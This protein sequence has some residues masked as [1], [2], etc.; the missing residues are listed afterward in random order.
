MTFKCLCNIKPSFLAAIT[1]TVCSSC[2]HD[3]KSVTNSM[4]FCHQCQKLEA[5]VTFS[6]KKQEQGEAPAAVAARPSLGI[7]LSKYFES[8]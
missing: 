8:A 2:G 4:H 6:S 1:N 7:V 3:H 5:Y